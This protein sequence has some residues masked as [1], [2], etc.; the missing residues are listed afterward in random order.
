MCSSV[1]RGIGSLQSELSRNGQYVRAMWE[2]TVERLCIMII[3]ELIV[4]P[5]V[6]SMPI[7][8]LLSILYAVFEETDEMV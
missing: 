4:E 5:F 8:Y 3:A 6:Q 1:S 2:F 7:L